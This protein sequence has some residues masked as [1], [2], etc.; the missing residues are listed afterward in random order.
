MMM[1]NM[2]LCGLMAA[3]LAAC[4]DA[5]DT[6]GSADVGRRDVGVDADAN[7]DAS[8]DA[9]DAS[10]DAGPTIPDPSVYQEC[11]PYAVGG[12]NPVGV[13]TVQIGGEPV[14]VWYPAA[15]GGADG[16]EPVVYDLREWIPEDDRAKIPDDAPTTFETGAYRDIPI[17]DGQ[18]PVVLFSHGL[19]G[20]RMQSTHFTV[21]LASWGMVV[22]APEHPERGLT[23]VLDNNLSF[24]GS[25]DVADLKATLDWLE[26][27]NQTAGDFF[28]GHLTTDAA[29]IT[30]HSAGG[31]AALATALED[32]RLV[33]VVGLAPA[34]GTGMG[35]EDPTGVQARKVLIAGQD[36][37]IVSPSGVRSYY[38]DAPAPKAY[39]SIAG[40]GHLAFSDICLIGREAGGI[41]AIAQD[42]GI[43]VNPIV[44]NLAQDGCRD[45]QLD[46]RAAWPIF[47]HFA[48]AELR[49]ALGLDDAPQGL[50][51]PAA[52]CFGELVADFDRVAE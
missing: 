25:E 45:D 19:A 20:Y 9:A 21:H 28:E 27:A 23:A 32:D 41:L 37:A 51:E 10:V 35:G 52:A 31:R 30:G 44:A 24:T 46:P 7:P 17:A 12:P 47:E 38:D 49:D 36:D 11:A 22:A 1:R 43:E 15:S 5:G 48:T 40:A 6:S 29:G 3:A 2:I 34:V 42:N 18:H 8:A 33:S 16:H 13:T 50:G 39:V 14:E 26:Q 4:D